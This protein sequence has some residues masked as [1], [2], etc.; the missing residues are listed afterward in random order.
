[1]ASGNR[2]QAIGKVA[3]WSNAP[4]SKSGVRSTRTVGSNPTLSATGLGSGGIHQIIFKSLLWPI[5]RNIP[6]K[7]LLGWLDQS[8]YPVSDI[9]LCH[10][11]RSMAKLFLGFFHP[12]ALL[13]LSGRFSAQIPELKHLFWNT[14]FLSCSIKSRAQCSLA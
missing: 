4:D 11:F 6:Q 7:C 12:C 14:R 9:P 10:R 2:D 5:L 1:M 8:T 13:F 3:E